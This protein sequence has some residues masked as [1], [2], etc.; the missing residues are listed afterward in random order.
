MHRKSRWIV[1]CLIAGMLVL[2]WIALSRLG[3][4]GRVAGNAPTGES[5]SR[6]EG[7]TAE[8]PS[9]RLRGRSGGA[10]HRG[11]NGVRPQPIAVSAR[12]LD[13]SGVVLSD[14]LRP[15]RGEIYVEL[16]PRSGSGPVLARVRCDAQARFD[17]TA[18]ILEE[19]AATGNLQLL[20]CRLRPAAISVPV[21]I[22]LEEPSPVIRSLRLR[23]GAVVTARVRNPDGELAESAELVLLMRH[24]SSGARPSWRSGDAVDAIHVIPSD[25][26]GQLRCVVRPGRLIARARRP[27][28]PLGPPMRASPAAGEVTDLGLLT[29]GKSWRHIRLSVRDPQGNAVSG[30]WVRTTD[31]SLVMEVAAGQGQ[32]AAPS[33]TGS[34]GTVI[35]PMP[36]DS[37]F[38]LEIAAASP[39]HLPNGTVLQAPPSTAEDVTDVGLVLQTR[40]ST[41]L[42]LE[43]ADN[44]GVALPLAPEACSLVPLSSGQPAGR[45]VK[46]ASLQGRLAARQRAHDIVHGNRLRAG[47]VHELFSS[48]WGEHRVEGLLPGGIRFRETVTIAESGPP[49]AVTCVIEP[50]RLVRLAATD[51]PGKSALR[52]VG[53][54]ARYDLTWLPAP[55]SD[56]G[57]LS[58]VWNATRE[59]P[60]SYWVPWGIDRVRLTASGFPDL[61]PRTYGL[62]TGAETTVSVEL[63]ALPLCQV[64]LQLSYAGDPMAIAHIPIDI[65]GRSAPGWS[66]RETTSE[67]G[68]VRIAL[69]VGAYQIGRSLRI[70]TPRWVGIE[71]DETMTETRVL[72]PLD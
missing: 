53:R 5:S 20:A 21:A 2:G 7:R 46:R 23:S 33:T 27:G 62:P 64:E 30:A 36:S 6:V 24:A 43:A 4:G 67:D 1:G 49:S 45:Q 35:L 34:D 41:Q 50:G 72:V 16:R 8:I 14:A 32:T 57:E 56:T 31:P 70:A 13:V 60:R 68:S 10:E 19:V 44:P 29:T 69:P 22:P 25:E 59:D 54:I 42:V 3:A 12:R 52:D 9:T 61:A 66:T 15:A 39:R 48:H 40:P 65:N 55:S 18:W 58:A 26:S 38:P 17:L 47:A 63:M 11:A 37:S 28:G 51:P 71:I